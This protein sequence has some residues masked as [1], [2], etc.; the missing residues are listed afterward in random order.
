MSIL[1]SQKA[2]LFSLV[3]TWSQGC[4]C[5]VFPGSDIF[6]VA[7]SSYIDVL[8]SHPLATKSLT[9]GALFG[10]GDVIAQQANRQKYTQNNENNEIEAPVFS[11]RRL[12]R[13]SLT[14][15]PNGALWATYFDFSDTLTT[16]L[17]ENFFAPAALSVASPSMSV[18]EQMI[19]AFGSPTVAFSVVKTGY[20]LLVEQFLWCPIVFSFYLI[21]V[22]TILNR[23]SSGDVDNR[24]SNAKNGDGFQE[25]VP[26]IVRV[27]AT[28]VRDTLGQLLVT[29]AKVWTLANLII[30]NVPLELRTITANIVDI[31]WATICSDMAAD[32]GGS[33]GSNDDDDNEQGGSCAVSELPVLSD[34]ERATSTRS[35]E[36]SG[37]PVL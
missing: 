37:V 3:F 2:A 19:V 24:V 4:E 27:A 15:I 14:G 17:T 12:L 26:V 8:H 21:P 28:E 10:V 18:A 29:N 22:S 11:G 34:Y 30:Y 25:S 31:I 16:G 7:S 33:T 35:R 1:K 13:Y 20:S 32:C 36:Q 6:S 9:S 23:L 5:L